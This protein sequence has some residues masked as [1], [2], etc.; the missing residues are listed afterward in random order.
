MT[1]PGQGRADY[2]AEGDFNAQCDQCGRKR[3]G[4]TLVQTWNGLMVCPEHGP[5]VIQRQPQDFVR[6]I[7]DNQMPPFTRPQTDPTFKIFCTPNG[8]SAVPDFA[9]PDCAIPDYL[10]PAFDPN[11]PE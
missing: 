6:G 10:S 7:A 9:I 8:S 4:S 2:Y 3:K 11:A 5:A 1:T